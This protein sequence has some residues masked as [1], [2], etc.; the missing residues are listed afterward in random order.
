[1]LL[2][3]C[4]PVHLLLRGVPPHAQPDGAP[5]SKGNH[6]TMYFSQEKKIKFYIITQHPLGSRHCGEGWASRR[7]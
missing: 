7:R 6:E 4:S 1:M 3:P 2:S 5:E